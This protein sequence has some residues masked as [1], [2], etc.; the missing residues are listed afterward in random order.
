MNVNLF[1]VQGS[2]LNM[3][4]NSR[5]YD[6]LTFLQIIIGLVGYFSL[7]CTSTRE[8]KV[9][10][11]GGLPLHEPSGCH[12]GAGFGMCV[13]SLVSFVFLAVLDKRAENK[14]QRSI[15]GWVDDI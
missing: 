5:I 15:S 9:C 1:D 12:F 13:M 8:G 4:V 3:V 7:V 6:A 10:S 2:S 11:N 14:L